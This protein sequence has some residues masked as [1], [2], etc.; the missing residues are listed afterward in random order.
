M[1][2]RDTL[3][4]AAEL[5]VE[6]DP[7]TGHVIPMPSDLGSVTP[8]EKPK[9]QKTIEQVVREMP[10]PNLDEIQAPVKEEPA[11]LPVIGSN[12]EVQFEAIY[13]M[14]KLPTEVFTA[15]NVLE[16]FAQLPPDLPMASKRATL[17]VTLNAMAKTGGV[18]IESVLADAS[19]KLAALASYSESYEKQALD[20]AQKA[21]AEVANLET[22]IRDLRSGIEEAKRRAER[23]ELACETESDRLDDVLEFFTVDAGPSKHA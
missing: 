6:F 8:S 18:S 5:F 19:R 16:L 4:K 14:A 15:E 7:D 13:K 21:E 10:G 9:P 3:R 12:G 1:R 17:N 11:N 22:K 20:F 23:V 2:V